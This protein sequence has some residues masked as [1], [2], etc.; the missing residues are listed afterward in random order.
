MAREVPARLSSG[1]LRGRERAGDERLRPVSKA[2]K[3][4]LRRARVVVNDQRQV[5][6]KRLDHLR[7]RIKIRAPDEEVVSRGIAEEFP[8]LGLALEDP[9][10]LGPGG[11]L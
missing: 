2:R 10:K 8:H 6:P 11:R 5:R 9:E 3:I 1:E 7:A 4:H